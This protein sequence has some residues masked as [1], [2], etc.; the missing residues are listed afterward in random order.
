MTRPDY[1]FLLNGVPAGIARSF[2]NRTFRWQPGGENQSPLNIFT[3]YYGNSLPTIC[4]STTDALPEVSHLSPRPGGGCIFLLAANT[5]DFCRILTHLSADKTSSLGKDLETT[6]NWQADPTFKVGNLTWKNDQPRIMGILNITP[7]SFY[8]GGNFFNLDDYCLIAEKMIQSGAD[9]IDIGG[10]SSRPGAQAVEE[11]EEIKRILK[12][13]K[14]IRHRFHIPLAI[15]TTKTAVASAALS[16]GADMINDVSGLASGPEMVRIIR[17]H[18]ASY[19]LMHIQGTPDNM[20]HN[21]HYDYIIGEIYQFFLSRLKIC[22][23]GGL[24]KDRILLDP[25]IGFG[26]TVQNNLDILRLLPAFSN[27]GSLIMIGTSNK[28]FIGNILGRELNDR[29]AGTMATQALGWMKG[30][31]VFRVHSVTE[32]KDVVEM[33]RCYTHEL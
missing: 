10:E 12:V 22:Q 25:G 14:Q 7:D 32:A 29:T 5:L 21:P 1:Q 6:F 30:A 19:C 31:T 18:N 13:V 28:S 9:I 24:A 11:D 20:Q 27:L 8:D 17:Q 23:A 3:R 16:A 33:A 15:D 26:K 2:L 4:S